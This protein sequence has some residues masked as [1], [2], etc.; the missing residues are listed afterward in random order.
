MAPAND[1]LP[2]RPRLHSGCCVFDAPEGLVVRSV[3][4]AFCI[5]PVHREAMQR[6]LA[7]LDGTHDFQQLLG[8]ERTLDAF[9]ALRILASFAQSGLLAEGAV[10]S[11][12]PPR[13]PPSALPVR[14]NGI[15]L[16]ALDGGLFS[17]ALGR[18]FEAL[19]ATVCR[20]DLA[21]ARACG[22]VAFACPDGPDLMSLEKVN[23]AA[24][25]TGAAWLPVFPFGDG[26]ITGPLFRPPTSP[27][28]RC[29][30]L[31]WLGISP[32]IA[33]EVAYFAHLRNGAFRDGTVAT[34][35]DA[36][37][38]AILVGS[39]AAGRLASAPSAGRVALTRPDL[40]T[41]TQATLEPCPQCDV[42]AGG[43]AP[44]AD[45][46]QVLD[47][48]LWIDRAVSLAE[49]G[50][51]LEALAGHPCGLVA[52]SLRPN[53]T[54]SA[55]PGLYEIAVARFALPEPED[56][57]SVQ[58][59]WCHGAAIVREEA[60]TLAIIE[61]LERYN[62]LSRPPPGIWAS[63]ASVISDAL[64]PTELPLFSDAQY[65]RPGFPF[66][67]FDP[68]RIVRWN[69]GYNLTQKRRV[70]IP[71]SAAWYGYNDSLLGD[72][73]NGVAA[74]SNR[75]H[76]LLNGVL[77]LVE[78]DAFMIHW[79]HRLSPPQV[80]LDD[81]VDNRSRA[82]IRC[83]E[84]SG[85][86]VR[87]FDLTTDLEIPVVLA[88][89]T[90]EDG[91]KPALIVGAGASLDHRSAL[92]RALSELYAATFSPTKLWT[93]KPPLDL[94][95][96]HGLADHSLAY[97]HPE[98]LRHASFLWAS[99]RRASWPTPPQPDRGWPDG[100]TKLIEQLKAYGHDVVGVDITGVDIARHGLFVVR[101]IVPGLQPL[102]LGTGGRLGGR[103]LYEVP[104]R[105]GYRDA[106]PQQGDLN[107]I[108]HCFP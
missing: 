41:T 50:P 74:H 26:I 25:A 69:W 101:A 24:R 28:F 90:H 18:S 36:T 58:D 7:R 52:I 15:T 13:T 86:A 23:I 79:L 39:L 100:L 94:A 45:H 48:T 21:F 49:L 42:C 37:R 75:S 80:D 10:S 108:P 35:E 98:W 104:V 29:F 2:D 55:H 68:E 63:Y 53:H 99:H 76:A 1:V 61:G 95:D 12:A 8:G 78:R 81:V 16:I 72:S 34:E 62:G 40:G 66:Q 5:E 4:G 91:R 64:L 93:L 89:G 32:S 107:P 56:V 102:A 97:E 27:C 71:T 77:E 38:L 31:R 59:N 73:S 96:V 22:A 19:G 20:G 11:K 87:I 57:G 65:V 51:N 92:F 103:R 88:L 84:E 106:P 30:E 43:P 14:L 83:V 85:Y 67:P 17:G 54:K 33:L 6:I 82:M 9:Y 105:M 3:A 44:G 70:L 60:R 47:E 46:T